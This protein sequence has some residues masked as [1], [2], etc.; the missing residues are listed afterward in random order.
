M[1]KYKSQIKWNK[2]N[3]EYRINY[4][5]THKEKSYLWARKSMLKA[6]YGITPEE[7]EILLISQ[8]NRCAICKIEKE[9]LRRSL[10]VDHCHRTGKI[11]GLL[12]DRCNVF[13]GYADENVEKLASSIKYIK[14]HSILG[15]TMKF[16][17]KEWSFN[18]KRL[19]EQFC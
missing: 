14:K 12:C 4:K 15:L 7:Y 9:K 19:N 17:H 6:K 13:I 3:P 8:D 2:E 16:N 10:A 1:A 18:L 11:R 5:K